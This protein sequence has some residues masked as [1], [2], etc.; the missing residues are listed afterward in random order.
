MPGTQYLAGLVTT[1]RDLLERVNHFYST[2]SNSMF[3]ILFSRDGGRYLYC[4]PS[5]R[6]HQAVRNRAL[7]AHKKAQLAEADACY[8]VGPCQHR[9]CRCGGRFYIAENFRAPDADSWGQCE[10][11]TYGTAAF[12]V[13][14]ADIATEQAAFARL[15][16]G[17]R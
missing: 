2:H 5:G 12:S 14:L 3:A 17:V 7:R 16:Q 6:S 10:S 1:D 11:G 13:M 9:G 8:V 4:F 15:K